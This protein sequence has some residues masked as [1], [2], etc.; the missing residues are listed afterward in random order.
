MEH[1][2]ATDGREKHVSAFSRLKD[3]FRKSGVPKEH[4]PEQDT[5]T[6]HDTHPTTA[7][8]GGAVAGAATGATLAD[9]GQSGDKDLDAQQAS[10]VVAE[11]EEG[12]PTTAAT[13]S[14]AATLQLPESAPL[15]HPVSPLTE[16][17]KQVGSAAPV[18]SGETHDR[19]LGDDGAIAGTS[20]AV[21]GAGFL[22]THEISEHQGSG[23]APSS[24]SGSAIA[25]EGLQ[26][27]ERTRPTFEQQPSFSLNPDQIPTTIVTS[28]HTP[29]LE[30]HISQ[31]PESDFDDSDDDSDDWNEERVEKPTAAA[32]V[33]A[34]PDDETSTRL[35]DQRAHP[36]NEQSTGS[37]TTGVP[38]DVPTDAISTMAIK[39]AHGSPVT[40]TAATFSEADKDHHTKLQKKSGKGKE[41]ALEPTSTANTASSAKTSED[42][43]SEP[44]VASSSP[45]KVTKTEPTKHDH[46]DDNNEKKGFRG[47]FSRIRNKS[48][49]EKQPGS[50][51][52]TTSSNDSNSVP[53][54][55][56]A[57]Q[58]PVPVNTATD[59]AKSENA[60][61]SPTAIP[62]VDTGSKF[63]V[64]TTRTGTDGAIGDSTRIAGIAGNS[65][66]GSPSSFNRHETNLADPDDVSSSG[67]DE[68]DV[69]RGR[70]GRV[71]K[72][73][74]FGNSRT[75]RKSEKAQGKE[76]AINS[77]TMT[78]G[79]ADME[80]GSSKNQDSEENDQFEEARDHFDESLAPPPAFGGQKKSESPVRE[81]KFKE[82]V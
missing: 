56:K 13:G 19:S 39:S 11:E 30:R 23:S 18:Q 40:G 38:K 57:S 7:A 52:T 42:K 67:V 29:T 73:M 49:S 32:G 55:T 53:N 74:G 16:E 68:D 51:M 48:K 64:P 66:P 60:A 50:F 47:L 12:R 15:A 69:E 25:D 78:K 27:E 26:R 17:E 79:S 62:P 63:E 33:A 9:I 22:G 35:E 54:P 34:V 1:G 28:S 77:T 76:K 21:V 6:E 8:T 45:S 72:K 41:P 58:K 81:T 3:H 36:S 80:R 5:A 20:G 4:K 75:T 43:T 70:N 10:H 59:A 2:A 44:V 14:T 71:V 65:E 37:Q 46:N 24:A 82:D 61:T 31:I